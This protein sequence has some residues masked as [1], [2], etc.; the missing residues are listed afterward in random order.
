M[1]IPPTGPPGGGGGGLCPSQCPKPLV[2]RALPVH[3]D[4]MSYGMHVLDPVYVFFTRFGGL[5]GPGHNL[6]MQFCTLYSSTMEIS[7]TDFFDILTIHN[8]QINQRKACFRPPLYVFFTLF[9]G[10]D[11]GGGILND[12]VTN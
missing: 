12:F 3:N 7:E 6:L 5:E 1:P 4:Q 10:L 11:R 8:N 2:D 9:G